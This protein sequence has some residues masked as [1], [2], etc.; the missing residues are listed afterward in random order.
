MRILVQASG[1]RAG[2]RKKSDNA[3]VSEPMTYLSSRFEDMA[4]N[5]WSASQWESP[6]DC[7]VLSGFHPRGVSGDT[8]YFRLSVG[9]AQRREPAHE[10]AFCRCVHT[11]A[12]FVLGQKQGNQQPGYSR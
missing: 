7:F 5:A 8:R 6:A 3:T 11:V 1:Q 12:A 2:A 9:S 10:T 4:C